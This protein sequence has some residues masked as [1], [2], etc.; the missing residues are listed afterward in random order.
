[1]TQQECIVALAVYAQERL[2]LLEVLKDRD[3]MIAKL[4]AELAEDDGSKAVLQ[5][6]N[7]LEAKNL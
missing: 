3:A 5:A 4:Q 7:E 6:V 2:M 1:M